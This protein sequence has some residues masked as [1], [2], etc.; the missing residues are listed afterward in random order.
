M[1]NFIAEYKQ[2]QAFIAAL[3]RESVTANLFVG[4][5]RSY[6]SASVKNKLDVGTY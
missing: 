4:D 6:L 2:N 1:V 3:H 5:W